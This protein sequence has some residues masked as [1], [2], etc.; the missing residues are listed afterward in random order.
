MPGVIHIGIVRHHDTQSDSI[1]SRVGRNGWKRLDVRVG[2]MSGW[3]GCQSGQVSDPIFTRLMLVDHRNTFVSKSFNTHI[4]TKPTK[5]G[6]SC[7]GRI[8]VRVDRM[9]GWLM[10][11][12]LMSG[13]LMSGLLDVKPM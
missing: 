6:R 12:W 4:S 11:G 9:S 13:W 2:W 3:V 10:S 8:D 1:K 5:S 7:Q